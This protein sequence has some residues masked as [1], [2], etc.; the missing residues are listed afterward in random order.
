MAREW[1]LTFLI[2]LLHTIFFVSFRNLPSPVGPHEYRMNSQL[3]D[4]VD[5]FMLQHRLGVCVGDQERDIV[6]L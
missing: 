6:T 4:K 3:N 2:N 5:E 1:V